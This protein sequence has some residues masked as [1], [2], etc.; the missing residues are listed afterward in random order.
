MINKLSSVS[1]IHETNKSIYKLSVQ[2]SEWL[3][4][5]RLLPGVKKIIKIKKTDKCTKTAGYR[6]P[7]E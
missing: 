6:I 4:E 5:S 1:S 3:S 7:T 2:E